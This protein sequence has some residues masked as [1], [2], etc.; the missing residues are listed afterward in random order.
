VYGESLISSAFLDFAIHN[1]ARPAIYEALETRG[2]GY[3][4]RIPANKNLEL[5][6]EDILFRSSGTSGG[7]W[8]SRRGSTRAR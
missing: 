2:V 6:I 3:A 7:G 5:E 4:I 8:C 1:F